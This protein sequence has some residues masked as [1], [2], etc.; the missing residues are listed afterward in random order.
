MRMQNLSPRQETM[1]T[2]IR[3]HIAEHGYPPTLRE[4]A[5]HMGIRSTNAVND[6]LRA[7]ERKGHIRREPATSRGITLAGFDLGR[8]QAPLEAKLRVALA[9]YTIV[10]VEGGRVVTDLAAE[11]AA[12]VV[13]VEL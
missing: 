3:A 13:G 10:A 1:L 11:L 4:I 9:R 12:F 7:M 2:F 8:P 6:H 5:A